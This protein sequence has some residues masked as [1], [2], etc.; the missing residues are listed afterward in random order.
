MRYL[1]LSTVLLIAATAVAHDYTPG[2]KQTEPILLKGGDLYTISDGVLETTD[3]LF[4]DGRITAIGENL[5]APPGGRVIDVTGMQVYPGLIAPWSALGLVEIGEVRATLDLQE[6]GQV[7]PEI[8]AHIAYN[9]DSEIIPTVRSNGITTAL[10]VPRGGVIS[11]RSSLMNLDGWTYEDAAEKLNL[12]L[13]VNWPQERIITAWWMEK[14]A[15]EQKEDNAKSRRQLIEA[16]EAA[17]SYYLAIQADPTIATDTRWEAMRPL[18]T[19]EMK[20]FIHADEYRQI[21]QAVAFAVKNNLRTVLVGGR[22]AHQ[23]TDL[24][25]EHDIP[26]VLGSLHVTPLRE[27]DDYDL[28]YRLPKLLS[29]AGVRFCISSG[30]SATGTMNLPFQAGQ[31]VAL[32]LSPEEA[33]RSVTLSAAEILGVAK[34]LGSLEVGKKATLIVAAGDILDV[35]T[36][37][38][39]L[40]FIEGREVDLDNR[41]REL[42]RKYRARP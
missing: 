15:E 42:Y 36:N 26:V 19:G 37:R 32:G 17:R 13:H 33:L 7:H 39:V 6:V 5:T 8:Q 9:T 1:V 4:I 35:L 12:G 25:K 10:I 3:L 41:H 18:F 16:F 21:E 11:G 29:E 22:E 38:V 30:S 14:T 2:T 27:D 28:P 40:E 24:L 34:D 23:L 31:A 20:L